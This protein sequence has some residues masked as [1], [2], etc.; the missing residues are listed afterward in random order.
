MGDTFRVHCMCERDVSK[1]FEGSVFN[2][3]MTNVFSE[4][5]RLI[6]P[7]NTSID[8]MINTNWTTTLLINLENEG[9]VDHVESLLQEPQSGLCI[10]LQEREGSATRSGALCVFKMH[11]NLLY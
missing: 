5:F 11:G 1:K 2:G 10:H 8:G 6:D 7:S 3:Q 4:R 9:M